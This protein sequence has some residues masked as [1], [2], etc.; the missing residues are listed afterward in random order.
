MT[1]KKH[2]LRSNLLMRFVR[3]H[4]PVSHFL[5]WR[6]IMNIGKLT[7]TQYE[8]IGELATAMSALGASSGLLAIVSSW[9]DTLP[10]I[11]ILAMIKD[12]NQRAAI[13]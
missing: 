11:E 3:V 6:K 12:W 13:N 10:E 8:I 4:Q 1:G 7:D 9:G 5:T 2:L